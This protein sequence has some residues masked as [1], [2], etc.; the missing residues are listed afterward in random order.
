MKSQY[1]TKQNITGGIFMRITNQMLALTAQKSGISLQPNTLLDIMNKKQSVSSDLISSLGNTK[2][3][4]SLLQK[5]NQKDD[6][7]LAASAESLGSYMSSL[8]EEGEDSLFGK[9]EKSGDTSELVKQIS[10]MKDAYNKTVKYLKNSDSP[11]NHFYMQELKSYVSDNAEALKAV[12][13]T[14]NNDGSL[15]INQDT[16][17]AAGVDELKAAF[18]SGSGFSEKVGYVSGRISENV[19]A[20][21]NSILSGYNSSGREALNAFSKNMY[22]FWG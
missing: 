14:R 5:L 18:G 1:N 2:N 4:N 6:K 8:Q 7:Q 17:S 16:L 20:V 3:T 12:G 21:S 13:V 10:N 22:N 15:S 11:L 19:S 9:A